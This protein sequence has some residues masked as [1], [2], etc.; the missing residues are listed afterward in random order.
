MSS[1][2]HLMKSQRAALKTRTLAAIEA[3]TDEEDAAIHAAAMSDPDNPPL[4]LSGS[5][6]VSPER[7]AQLRAN[8]GEAVAN[9]KRRGRPAAAVTKQVVNMRLDRDVVE[10][11]KADGDGWQTRA[12]A[13][14]RK[15]VGL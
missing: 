3:T 1:F 11:L 14:L 4:D 10:R 2:D 6:P 15:A 8:L 9:A 7:A 12:N 5:Q 13:M